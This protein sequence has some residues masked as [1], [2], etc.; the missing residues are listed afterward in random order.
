MAVA[1]S[2]VA[3][4]VIC[5]I[6][7]TFPRLIMCAK[8]L[9]KDWLVEPEGDLSNELTVTVVHCYSTPEDHG[10]REYLE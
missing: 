4:F 2:T 8:Q 6:T 3:I 7:S 9:I 1:F 10:E 5:P